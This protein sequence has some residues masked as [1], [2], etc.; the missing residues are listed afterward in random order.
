MR[1]SESCRPYYNDTALTVTQTMHFLKY[2]RDISC[3]HA[4]LILDPTRYSEIE[5]KS[6]A[7]D[8]YMAGRD[9]NYKG[10]NRGRVLLTC[11][12]GTSKTQT[13]CGCFSEHLAP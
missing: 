4:A 3:F 2:K 13:S 11:G 10:D 12:V 1:R 7:V 9:P 6:V 5:N 8:V